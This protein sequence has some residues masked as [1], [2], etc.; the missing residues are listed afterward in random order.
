MAC[1]TLFYTAP[2]S[3]T[4]RR[5]EKEVE[6]L[7]TDF[8]YLLADMEVLLRNGPDTDLALEVADWVQLIIVDEADRLKTAGL[9]QMRDFYDRGRMGLVFI[10]MPGI[11]KRLSRYPQLYS[12]VGFVH[13]FQ[14]LST[15]EMQFIL[16][17]KWEQL[18]LLTLDLA[19]Y[20]DA[21]ALAAI[22]RIVGGNFRLLE[23]LMS[24]VERVMK[25]NELRTLTKEVVETAR[26]ALIIG[27]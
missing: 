6:S 2:V 26:K 25:I 11:E 23:R 13:H 14:P 10:G 18:G 1:T 4:A 21:E 9:E 24:Q 3:S 15:E 22:I 16:Q 20:T 8:N 27:P 12:R 7:R 5:I 17:N 19:D